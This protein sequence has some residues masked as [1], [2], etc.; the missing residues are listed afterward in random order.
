MEI[1]GL[2]MRKKGRDMKIRS[3]VLL[4]ILLL[5]SS[6][7]CYPL[8]Y[9]GPYKGKVID[10]ETGKPIE[11]VVVLGVWYK[12][13]ATPA[14]GVSS[15]YDAAETV[16]D[17]NG[18][19]EIRGLGLKILTNV[20]PM[21]VLIFK[22]GYQYIGMGP[23]ESFKEDEILR[24]RVQWEVNRAII[25]LKRLTIEGRKR[26]GSPDFPS[27]APRH[28]IREILEE[29]NKDRNERGLKSVGIGR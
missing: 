6:S 7:C 20:G 16:T 8:R 17:K 2:L 5:L 14:G 4:S 19:F 29:I 27:E 10:A 23:W 13:I 24:R 12:E 11:G 3:L 21:D 28:K 15:Y 26:Q 1:Q 9:D 22:A 25:R 18:E